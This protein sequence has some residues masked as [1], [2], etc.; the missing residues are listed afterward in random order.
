MKS[1]RIKASVKDMEAALR[2]Y[3]IWV[4]QGYHSVASKYRRSLLGSFWIAGSLVA[5]SLS[6]AIVFGGIFG[7]PMREFLPYITSGLLVWAV[8]SMPLTEGP[9]TFIGSAHIIKNH[10]YPLSYYAFEMIARNFITLLHNVLVFVVLSL[11]VRTLAPVHWTFLP[12]MVLTY[13][14]IV[15]YS[16]LAG[17]LGA[18]FRDVRFI[19][20]YLAQLLFFI[21]PIFWKAELIHGPRRMI[22]ELNPLYHVLQLM[23]RPLLGLPPT[24]DNWVNSGIVLLVGVVLWLIF[25]SI[26]RRRIA[27]WI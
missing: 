2:L 5:T 26:N 20:P 6:L 17:M 3:R 27:F 10:A 11:C 24:L 8:I 16:T 25:F 7:Q 18:R 21:T 9:E 23:R 19:F 1:S 22:A 14:I 4:Y 12:G 15:F 13:A